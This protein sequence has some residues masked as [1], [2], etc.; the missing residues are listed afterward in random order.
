MPRLRGRRGTAPQG[1]L[2]GL[3]R[4]GRGR[5]MS[6]EELKEL[7]Q[8][9]GEAFMKQ[10]CAA[11]DKA[12]VENLGISFLVVAVNQQGLMITAATNGIPDPLTRIGLLA[13]AIKAEAN[14]LQQALHQA[15][16]AETIRLV[17]ESAKH[18]TRN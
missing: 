16:Q 3:P 8:S 5:E 17:Q 12:A 2:P 14:K 1:G 13:E 4:K 9:A 18:M 11:V 10:V 15:A 7:Q 6:V